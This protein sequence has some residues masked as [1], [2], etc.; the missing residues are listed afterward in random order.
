MGFQDNEFTKSNTSQKELPVI[1]W[2]VDNNILKSDANKKHAHEEIQINYLKKGTVI[3]EVEDDTILLQA[4]QAMFLN[5]DVMHKVLEK[6]QA[7]F[8]MIGLNIAPKALFAAMKDGKKSTFGNSVPNYIVLRP[9]KYMEKVIID[10]TLTL[11]KVGEEKEPGFET[12]ML[13]K[14]YILFGQGMEFLHKSSFE[15]KWENRQSEAMH[16]ML[17]YIHENYNQNVNIQDVAAAGYVSR[18]QC[19][20]IFRRFM[21]KTPIEYLNN[22]KISKSM[23]LMKDSSLNLTEISSMCGF[24]SPSYFSETFVKIMQCTPSKYR[25]SIR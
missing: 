11:Y 2:K 4:G 19:Y 12:A 16:R 6:D 5:A 22:Y 14:L 23:E 17:A 1:T 24:S 13:G 10:Q 3:F 9:E 18:S 15:S 8:E 20:M 7:E 21:D 25:K